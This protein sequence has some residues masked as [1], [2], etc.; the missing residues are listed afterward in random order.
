MGHKIAFRLRREEI[1]TL[2]VDCSSQSNM[3]SYLHTS[4]VATMILVKVH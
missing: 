2:V 3:L 4:G 1:C